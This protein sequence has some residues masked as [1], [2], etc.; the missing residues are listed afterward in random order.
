MAVVQGGVVRRPQLLADLAKV[1]SVLLTLF[2][3]SITISPF[4]PFSIDSDGRLAAHV[5][6]WLFL[7]FGPYIAIQLH[8][9]SQRISSDVG[10]FLMDNGLALLAFIVGVVTFILLWLRPGYTLTPDQFHIMLQCTMWSFIDFLYG[11]II[12]LRI[13]FAGKERE[14]L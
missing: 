2:M 4:L 11:V 13:A 12:T 6:D 5:K 8:E 9:T 1:L 10:D 3:L 7:I 14:E